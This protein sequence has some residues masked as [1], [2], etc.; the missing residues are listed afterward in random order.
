MDKMN[1]R[2]IT[3]AVLRTWEKYLNPSI[4]WPILAIFGN[5]V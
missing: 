3:S 4:V 2:I 5:V 1:N